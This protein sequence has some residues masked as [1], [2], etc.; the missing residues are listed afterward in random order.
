MRTIVEDDVNMLE[1]EFVG[2]VSDQIRNAVPDI[3][4]A[5]WAA[6][7]GL[8]ADSQILKTIRE[9]YIRKT[10][11]STFGYAGIQTISNREGI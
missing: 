10:S 7:P 8:C 11:V 6:Y 4:L 1:S 3:E 5:L 9:C 2:V